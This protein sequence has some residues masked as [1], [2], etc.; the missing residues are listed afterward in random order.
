MSEHAIPPDQGK[1][2]EFPIFVAGDD[3]D[4]RQIIF[5]DRR[6]EA[7]QVLREG[8]YSPTLDHRLVELTFPGTKSWDD[9]EGIDLDTSEPR[10][11]LIGKSDRLFALAIDDI[12]YELPFE[13]M[14]EPKLRS[15]AVIR[16]DKV[17]VLAREGQPDR[18]LGPGD[19]VTFAGREVER[20]FS[21]DATVTVCLDNEGERELPRGTYMF[22]KIV[23][24]LGI[25]AGFV[26]SYV[27][28]AGKLIS[29]KEDDKVELFD[30]IKFF[31]H[32]AG[33]GAS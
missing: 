5:F 14:G 33:G 16:D 20:L 10:H 27:N 6:V 23:A 21:R 26:L 22:D 4:F 31:S 19:V 15:M 18:D 13:E 25:P 2:R 11:F 30:G 32:A 7:D 8:G 28:A 12:V 29:F 24:L 9:D 3:L 1:H 17:L